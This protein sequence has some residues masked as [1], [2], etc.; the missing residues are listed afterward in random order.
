MAKKDINEDMD[1]ENQKYSEI[2]FLGDGNCFFD[3][4]LWL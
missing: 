2:F 4:F 3:A 1:L